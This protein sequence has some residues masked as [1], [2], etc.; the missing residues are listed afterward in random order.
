MKI[1]QYQLISKAQK[2]QNS[3]EHKPQSNVKL[4]PHG[5]PHALMIPLSV[6]LDTKDPG[7]GQSAKDGQ[8]KDKDQLID[9]G[10]A[11]HLLRSHPPDHNIVKETYK[12]GNAVLD[13]DG[14]RHL[15]NAP[16]KLFITDQLTHVNPKILPAY[17][18][19]ILLHELP[20]WQ[21]TFLLFLP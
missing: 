9:N 1:Q 13:H 4:K 17:S 8:V 6:K 21:C 14:H 5:V 10:Y 11:A 15:Q 2:G 12:I 3:K 18:V 19:S 20:L 7:G 16:V